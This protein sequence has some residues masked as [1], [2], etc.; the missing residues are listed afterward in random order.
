MNVIW[1]LQPVVDRMAHKDVYAPIPQTCEYATLLGKRDFVNVI[2]VL[3]FV[4]RRV[5]WFISPFT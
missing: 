2:K 1:P 4:V 3:D 5:S